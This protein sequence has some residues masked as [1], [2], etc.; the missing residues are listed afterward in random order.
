MLPTRT[1]P[2]GYQK[3]GSLDISKDRRMMLAL[4][5]IG[6]ALTILWGWVFF[7]AILFLRPTGG[8]GNVNFSFNLPRLALF[9]VSVLAL[10]AFYV[11]LHEAIHGFFFWRFTRARPYF[12]FRWTYA[13][14]AA[15]EWYL[16][17][18]QYLVTAL[19]PLV[20]I[21]AAGL[22]A[23]PFVPDSWVIPL[24]FVLTMNAGGAVGDIAVAIWLLTLSPS[25]LAQ[26]RG[27]SVTLFR[28]E[29]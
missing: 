11:T 5:V 10:M 2:T 17:R 12:A 8:I 26:D 25:A 4:N 3:A 13:Y 9:I 22:V 1:L 20:L 7:R 14:A 21:T 29:V 24:W 23:A 19:A 15:P 28:P 6:T 16:P 18:N 27:N